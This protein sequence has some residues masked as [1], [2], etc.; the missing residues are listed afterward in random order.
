LKLKQATTARCPPPPRITP[1]GGLWHERE[2]VTLPHF[3]G[4]MNVHR[5]M[6]DYLPL[7]DVSSVL[8]ILSKISLMGGVSDAQRNE[9]FSLLEIRDFKKGEYVSKS[10][11]EPSRVFIVK[12][13]K[14][15]LLINNSDVT[16][17]KMEFNVGDCF[18]EAAMLSM[19]NN[20]ASFLATEDSELITLSKRALNQLR[21]ED[22][23][24]FCILIM[25]LAR[26]LARKL[27]FTDEI[28]LKQGHQNR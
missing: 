20:T 27:Q 4:K 10:G 18:G 22:L 12:K 3:A 11:E 1:P 21:H 28:L 16:I 7:E 17:R 23:N 25:N 2:R 13:G 8:P 14:I 5:P 24:L 9:I 26:D 15:D 19:I 6:K